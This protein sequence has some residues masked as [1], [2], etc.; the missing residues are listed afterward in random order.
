MMTDSVNKQD[1]SNLI[2]LF[3]LT[4]TIRNVYLSVL[5]VGPVSTVELMQKANLLL[6][7]SEAK[8]YLDILVNQNYLEKYKEDDLIKYKVKKLKR[9]TRNV[10]KS[11]W[12]N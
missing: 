6:D 11:I 9:S 4:E 3:D 1:S 2:G 5:K 10:P 12:I 8:A 7:K